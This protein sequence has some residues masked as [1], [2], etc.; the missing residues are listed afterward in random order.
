MLVI[1]RFKKLGELWSD[2]EYTGTGWTF[3]GRDASDTRRGVYAFIG[4]DG[5]EKV[6]KAE[7]ADGIRARTNQYTLSKKRLNEDR[8]DKS[9]AL[10]DEV[11]NDDLKDRTLEFYFLPVESKI[12]IIH[13]IE[14]EVDGIRSFEKTLSTQARAEENPMR[15]SGKGN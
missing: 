15:L 13:G 9:D 8:A 6:G 3:N 7:N 12:E 11:M 2:V 10:W 1:D 5:I 14:I 4:I